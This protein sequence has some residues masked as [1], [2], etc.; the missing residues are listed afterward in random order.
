[1][2]ASVYRTL[3]EWGDED[4]MAALLEAAAREPDERARVAAARELVDRSEEDSIPESLSD[5]WSWATEHAAFD[6][7]ARDVSTSRSTREVGDG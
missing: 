4:A 2:R 3:G 5:A 1:V 7:R 6:R